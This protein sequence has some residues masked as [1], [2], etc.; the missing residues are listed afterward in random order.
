VRQHL[1]DGGLHQFRPV[2]GFR[3]CP[4]GH[5]VEVLAAPVLPYAV[6]GVLVLEKLGLVHLPNGGTF[7]SKGATYTAQRIY[8]MLGSF[9]KLS[10]RD[11]DGLRPAPKSRQTLSREKRRHHLTG[12][13]PVNQDEKTRP[14]GVE[15]ANHKAC[16]QGA[17]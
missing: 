5:V 17:Q 10:E 6:S 11:R 1:S 13:A 2:V 15:T 8:A 4:P 14:Q 9:T 12:T 3:P 16:P 7:R